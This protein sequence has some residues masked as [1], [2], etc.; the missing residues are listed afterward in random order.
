[1]SEQIRLFNLKLSSALA[2]ELLGSSVS[3]RTGLL[4]S[5][6][7]MWF[8]GILVAFVFFLLCKDAV[9]PSRVDP[10]EPTCHKS[11]AGEQTGDFYPCSCSYCAA[12]R[13]T[14]PRR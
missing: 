11:P 6:L 8:F 9:V 13:P 14:H 2:R 3:Y 12:R 4:S 10:T 5:A 7:L 1:M